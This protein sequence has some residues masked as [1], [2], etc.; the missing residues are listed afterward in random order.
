MKSN[1]RTDS[2]AP[3]FQ[4][5]LR[6]K[7]PTI[8]PDEITRTLG[9]EPEHSI[10]AGTAVS[11]EGVRRLH[12]E[13]YWIAQLSMPTMESLRDAAA[14]RLGLIRETQR[15]KAPSRQA[16]EAMILGMAFAEWRKE[17]LAIVHNATGYDIFIFTCLK[18]LEDHGDFFRRI[19]HEGG[20]VT[21]IVQRPDYDR[22][23]SIKQTLGRLAELGIELE[24]D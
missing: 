13:S 24:I 16:Q 22:P 19:N 8:D 7:H 14:K 23:V 6:I 9:L 10:N 11:G 17:D 12:C 18:R 2:S 5:C 3:L 4:L 21:L 20:S 15:R 1:V